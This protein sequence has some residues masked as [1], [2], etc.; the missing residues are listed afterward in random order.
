MPRQSH[1]IGGASAVANLGEDVGLDILGNEFDSATEYELLDHV[2]G[3]AYGE[4]SRITSRRR[5]HRPASPAALCR[6]HIVVSG[7]HLKCM[8]TGRQSSAYRL[9]PNSGAEESVSAEQRRCAV[10]RGGCSRAVRAASSLASQ[11][12]APEPNIP[13]GEEKRFK[14]L[15]SR[16]CWCA[17]YLCRLRAVLPWNVL[18]QYRVALQWNVC[19]RPGC[20]SANPQGS[21]TAMELE[22]CCTNLATVLQAA[23][24]RG[25]RLPG[26]VVHGLMRQLLTGIAA[27]HGAGT[28]HQWSSI[29]PLSHAAR[30]QMWTVPCNGAKQGTEGPWGVRCDVR[31]VPMAAIPRFPA[32]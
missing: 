1:S 26:P 5:S 31:P 15:L 9:R 6:H 24:E 21:S 17:L 20:L 30:S 3:G 4:V 2:G 28:E 25:S 29:C 12:R 16:R 11:C 10:T 22:F 32:S 14:P 13:A 23:R 18:R 8:C 19:L 7:R 27:C